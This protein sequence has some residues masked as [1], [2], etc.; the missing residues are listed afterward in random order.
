LGAI[1]LR[2]STQQRLGN[3]LR[4]KLQTVH[5]ITVPEFPNFFM[6][7]GPQAPFAN[8]PLV[9]DN[10][11][12]WIGK[13]MSYMRTKGYNGVVSNEEAAEKWRAHVNLVFDST[14]IAQ[15][16]KDVGAWLVGANVESKE[17]QTLF[18]FGGVPAYIATLE[19]EIQDEYPSYTFT[20]A[21]QAV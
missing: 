17:K 11:S 15:S 3:A 7:F 20:K 8:G 4:K 21:T 5:G 13:M 1:E 10:T 19:K 2:G 16:S 14:V 12:D 18:Y 6:I 9:I